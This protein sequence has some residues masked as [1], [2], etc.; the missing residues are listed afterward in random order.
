MQ[1]QYLCNVVGCKG[2]K[3]KLMGDI[4]PNITPNSPKPTKQFH[5]IY[6]LPKSALK[7]DS[8]PIVLPKDAKILSP[9]GQLTVLSDTSSTSASSNSLQKV[10]IDQKAAL[11]DLAC[12]GKIDRK[13]AVKII[14]APKIQSHSTRIETKS[15]EEEIKFGMDRKSKARMLHS[16]K[17]KALQLE[18]KKKNTKLFDSIHKAK[19]NEFG[20]I[21]I[22]Q[23]RDVPKS[24][25]ESPTSN[26]DSCSPPP[27]KKIRKDEILCCEGC[28]CYGMAGDFFSP[29]VCCKECESRANTK[30]STNEGKDRCQRPRRETTRKAVVKQEVRSK[31][32]GLRSLNNGSSSTPLSCNSSCASL[33]SDGSETR[34]SSRATTPANIDKKRIPPHLEYPWFHPKTKNFSWNLYLDCTSSKGAP[35][36]L[37]KHNVLIPAPKNWFNVGMKLEAVDPEHP[38]LICVVSIADV[39]GYRLRLHFDGFPDSYDFWEC[40]DSPNIFP[41]GWSETKSVSAPEKFFHNKDALHKNQASNQDLSEWKVGAKLEAVDRQNTSMVCVATVAEILGARILIHFDGWEDDYDYWV[42]P[43]SPYVHY[44]GW[45]DEH[46][47]ELNPPNDFPED[48]EFEWDAYL[49][50]TKSPVV[51]GHA[52]KCRQENSSFKKHMKLEVVDKR[53]PSLIRVATVV[54]VNGRQIK[55]HFDGWPDEY[56]IWVEDDSYEI[57][58]PEWCQKVNG[59]SIENPLTSD[60]VKFYESEGKCPTPGCRGIGHIKGPI[61]MK[62][63]TL[64]SCPYSPQNLDLDETYLTDRFKIKESQNPILKEPHDTGE[65]EEIRQSPREIIGLPDVRIWSS[66]DVARF[67]TSLPGLENNLKLAEIIFRRRNRRI[68]FYAF[69]TIRLGSKNITF[70][71]LRLWS[72]Q[73]KEDTHKILCCQC[74]VPIDPNPANTCVGCLRTQ[75][76]ITEDIPK[77]VVLNFCKFCERYLNPPNQWVSCPLESRE[78]MALSEVV[79]ATILQQTFV[80]EYVVHNQMCDDCHRVEAK[81]TWNASVQVRQKTTQRK[82]LYYLEQVLIKYNATKDCSGIKVVHE[83]LDFF[84][85]NESHARKLVEFLGTV[86]PIR[87]QQAKKLISHDTNSNTYNYKYTFSV[88][89]VPICKDNIVCLPP[90]VAHSLGGMGQIALVHKVTN[91]LHLLDPSTCQFAEINA[92]SYFRTPFLSLTGPKSF[93]EYTVMNIEII[94]DFDRRKFSGQGAISK[95]HVLADCWVVRSSELG[96][97][98]EQIHARTHLGHILQIGDSVM[99]LNLKKLQLYAQKCVRNRRRKWKLRHMDGVLGTKSITSENQEMT[100]FL[101]D[102]E[103]DMDMRQHINIY[104]DHRKFTTAVDEDDDDNEIPGLTLLKCWS[105]LV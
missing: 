60:E 100:D 57:F 31:G 88:E 40:G 74:G 105:P 62:H 68:F 78:M 5:R 53:N 95:R 27:A 85:S 8:S 15:S 16:A 34:E 56:D 96:V 7:S 13:S 104:K 2:A 17:S 65:K 46:N 99:G 55:V 84:F 79:S 9:K 83:G 42:S 67:V 39:Q 63:S 103:E 12:N 18:S 86:V 28:G 21:E 66:V 89:V 6:V 97:N 76:D 90:K 1:D 37:F 43:D 61:F 50:K 70:V 36:K 48:V 71:E 49:K 73:I 64:T 98:D 25:Q 26:K 59:T 102:I 51:P 69:T 94:S 3:S 4:K 38:S 92:N 22:V 77:Q 33:G 20:A 54:K 24:L 19:E 82:T 14:N 35:T 91:V 44:K 10:I 41:A 45:C 58:P 87:Y 52:F 47:M 80:V 101:E 30:K 72:L 93:T 11:L 32:D 29:L 75:V 81:D 23:V